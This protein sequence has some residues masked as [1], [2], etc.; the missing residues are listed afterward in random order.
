MML[1]CFVF[2]R[3]QDAVRVLADD[4]GVSGDATCDGDEEVV[5]AAAAV[6]VV[7]V[8]VDDH[9]EDAGSRMSL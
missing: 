2:S 8:V 9:D 4:S 3:C 5:V 7:A 6:A 1:F